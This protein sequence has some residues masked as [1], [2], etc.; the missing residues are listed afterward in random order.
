MLL[1]MSKWS[2]VMLERKA[3]L[4]SGPIG[5]P[6]GGAAGAMGL[7]VPSASWEMGTAVTVGSADPS[8]EVTPIPDPW[9]KKKTVPA[10]S[11]LQKQTGGR[12]EKEGA[13]R[14]GVLSS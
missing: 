1:D 5:L 14:R 2:M 6:F 13:R 4:G 8:G 3:A 9:Q 12:Q 11:Y 7:G 10:Y